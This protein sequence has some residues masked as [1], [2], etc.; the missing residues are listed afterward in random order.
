MTTNLQET[1]SLVAM[2]QRL[3]QVSASELLE[4]LERLETAEAKRL[5]REAEIRERIAQDLTEIFNTESVPEPVPTPP[6]PIVPN[7]LTAQLQ[8]SLNLATVVAN[9]KPQMHQLQLVKSKL[10]KQPCQQYLK[11]L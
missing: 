9:P 2:T 1:R 6:P 11:Y 10:R 7:L 5:Q 4:R 3:G 8:P